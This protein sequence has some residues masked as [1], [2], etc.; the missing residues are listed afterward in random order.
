MFLSVLLSSSSAFPQH[1]ALPVVNE[2]PVSGPLTAAYGD[3]VQTPRGLA[4]LALEGFSED[5]NQDGYVD[6]VVQAAVPAAAVA[7]PAVVAAA[8]A[9]VS[10][11][12]HAAAAVPTAAYHH[13]AAVPVAAAVP[14]ATY[15]AA[16]L[17]AVA[18]PAVAAVP[19]A[20]Y[21]YAPGAVHAA[22]Y[23]YSYSPYNTVH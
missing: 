12:H 14:A 19:A 18:A 23:G 9:V 22:N 1:A 8:P 13:A 17:P 21:A 16:A 20:T 2:G 10:T 4:S 11:Y 3:L 7:A 15:H 5:L 6:P